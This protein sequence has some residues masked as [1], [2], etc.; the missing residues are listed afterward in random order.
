MTAFMRF[1]PTMIVYAVFH[2]IVGLPLGPQLLW[3]LP[4]VALLLVLAAGA[5]MITAAVQV[6]F[7]DLR[8]IL[9]YFLRIW[10]YASPV[11]YFADEVPDR[12]RLILAA[13]PMYPLLGPLSDAVNLGE[14][15]SIGL[16]A[17]GA[18]W[19]VGM[20]IVGALF[21]ISR[22]REFAVRL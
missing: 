4:I 11:L 18:A 2:V 8:N 3:A 20:F 15:P 7:R 9:T 5:A 14:N 22:E 17:W 6:Y 13:N 21:F 10:L 1:I 16:L 19:S 12:F